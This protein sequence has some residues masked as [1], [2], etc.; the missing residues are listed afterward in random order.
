MISGFEG[1]EEFAHCFE[2]S[3][4]GF[5]SGR[6]HA[7]GGFG[8]QA[9]ER[10]VARDVAVLFEA[11]QMQVQAAVRCLQTFFERREVERTIHLQGRQDAQANGAVHV[12]VEAV[13]IN[14]CHVAFR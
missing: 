7:V 4:E 5:S 3:G 14:W 11:S 9:D 8:A 13:E 12:R 6:G 2:V 1:F 10:F